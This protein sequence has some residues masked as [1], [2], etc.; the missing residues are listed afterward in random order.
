MNRGH[1]DGL[2][3][4]CRMILYQHLFIINKPHLSVQPQFLLL[5]FA[6]LYKTTSR[7][8]FI[9]HLLCLPDR[10]KSKINICVRT[11]HVQ[12][13]YN[14]LRMYVERHCLQKTSH[15]FPRVTISPITTVCHLDDWNCI[16]KMIVIPFSLFT[17]NILFCPFVCFLPLFL[18]LLPLGIFPCYSLCCSLECSSLPVL[19]HL[20]TSSLSHHCCHNSV[21][22]SERAGSHL[23]QNS[24]L[25]ITFIEL[26][27][28]C[29]SSW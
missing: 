9:L 1:Q 2:K 15:N 23:K 22:F 11:I 19:S 16:S 20:A 13:I 8:V 18:A 28:S 14:I 26:I 5:H 4:F 21:T 10:I 25:P 24:A 12:Y 27:W 17:A 3:W 7:S 6:L 29:H